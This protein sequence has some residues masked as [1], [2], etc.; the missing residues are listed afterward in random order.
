[1]PEVNIQSVSAVDARF[2]LPAGAG[3][4]SVHT[5]SEYCMAVT[6]LSSDRQLSGTGIAFTLGDG[7]RLVCDAIELLAKPLAGMEINEPMADFG[8]P[9][10]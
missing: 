5:K 3:T 8:C 2:A 6:R 7:N 1:M 9:V 4:D 10:C